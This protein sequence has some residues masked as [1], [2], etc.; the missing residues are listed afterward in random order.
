MK[1]HT[2]SQMALGGSYLHDSPYPGHSSG[3]V[4]RGAGPAYRAAGHWGGGGC[5]G[6]PSSQGDRSDLGEIIYPRGL[7][8]AASS[9]GPPWWVKSGYHRWK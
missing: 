5:I 3:R 7:G 6:W 1:S 4:E 2:P 9:T 8:Y